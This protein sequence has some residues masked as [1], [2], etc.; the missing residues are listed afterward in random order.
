MARQFILSWYRGHRRQL[1]QFVYHNLLHADDPPHRLALG[2]AIGMF[3]AF[4][5][6]VGV[7]MVF[8]G[9]LSWLL[10]ANKVVSVAVVWISNPGTMVPIYWYCYRIGCAVLALDPVGRPWWSDLAHPPDRWWPAVA[11]YWSR[12]MEIAGPLWLGSSIVGVICGYVT[13]YVVYHAIRYH[14]HQ[15]TV[16][17]HQQHARDSYVD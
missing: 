4:T 13:Y 2:M 12:L 7:Q 15:N 16:G 8:A 6:T 17:A 3:V 14:R 5:P 1:R 11:F 9:F 10:R